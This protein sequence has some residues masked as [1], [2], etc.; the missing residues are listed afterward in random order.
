[1]DTGLPDAQPSSSA[2]PELPFGIS[3]R[4]GTNTNTG[5]FESN[6]RESNPRNFIPRDANARASF[7]APTTEPSSTLA[8]LLDILLSLLSTSFQLLKL[9]TSP[10]I[11]ATEPLWRPVL[12]TATSPAFQ[13]GAI[14][15]VVF[16]VVF[17]GLIVSSTVF[18]GILYYVYVPERGWGVELW[19][20]YGCVD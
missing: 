3:R 13:R 2:A 6:A 11:S 5:S 4:V 18:Y 10:I 19:L 20:Q 16:S 9:V 8:T 12:D 15:L 1:M 17:A 7:A 14:G